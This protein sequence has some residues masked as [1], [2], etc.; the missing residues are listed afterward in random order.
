MPPW[1]RPAAPSPI[2][3]TFAGS[4]SIAGLIRHGPQMCAAATAHTVHPE[5]RPARLPE[6][7]SDWSGPRRTGSGCGRRTLSGLVGRSETRLH[8]IPCGALRL[9]RYPGPRP[10]YGPFARQPDV[11]PWLTRLP[12]LSW[13]QRG[14]ADPLSRG[15]LF[16]PRFRP[17]M[18][19]S[20]R[21]PMLPR[22]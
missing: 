6:P 4:D 3:R 5:I 17:M 22:A 13:W 21:G 12:A 18:M 8:P 14:A 10:T 16:L 1:P 11:V 7:P 20:G 15:R 2:W 19:T 9:F